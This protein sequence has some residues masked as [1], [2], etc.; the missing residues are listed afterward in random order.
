M[1]LTQTFCDL[2]LS[3]LANSYLGAADLTRPEPK[4]PL[5]V[6]VCGN[7]RLVQVPEIE[8][9]KNIFSDYA[10]FSSFADGWVEHC[11]A[12]A[13]AAVG[14]FGLSAGH[15]VVEIASNDGCLLQAFKRH[16]VNILG[17]EP[18]ANVAQEAIT[19]GI[20]TQIG[21]FGS[22]LA[23]DLAANRQAADL[24]VANNVL[25]HV[26][27][28]NDF[29]RGLA[30]LLKPEGAL[31]IEFPSLLKL[32]EET[33]FDTI[34]H[35]HFSYFCLLTAERALKQHGLSVFDV[36]DLATH[37]GSLRVYAQ[38]ATSTRHA[39]TERVEAVRKREIAAGLDTPA[40]YDKFAEKVKARK[41]ELLA[42][43]NTA[44]AAGKTVVAYGAPAKGN[45]LL[46]YCGIGCETLDYTVDRSPHK[47]GRFLPGSHIPIRHPDVIRQTRPDYV[48][49]LPWNWKEEII[50]EL[51]YIRDWGGRFVIP[52]PNVEVIA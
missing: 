49:V 35:E 21:F 16:G 18:A 11:N 47:Q 39:V 3:P 32:I 12:F 27:D 23:A 33:Q 14:R 31:S 40:I 42:F 15:R 2:G 20:P 46:N 45:T 8:T 5:H 43:L 50:A 1:P 36:E 30:A 38:R 25:A 51:A 28:L 41:Q 24:L 4:Y 34:Y 37:G 13:N 9:P 48:L 19:R 10:Y 44:K 26:P 7:C 22:R 17:V 52:V 29:V 6:R